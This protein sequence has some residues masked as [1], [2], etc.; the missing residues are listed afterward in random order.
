MAFGETLT[1]SDIIRR[2]LSSWLDNPPDFHDVEQAYKKLG[3]QRRII[4]LLKRQ[5]ESLEDEIKVQSDR[6]RSNDTKQAIIT[7]TNQQRDQLAEL[8]SDLEEM[9]ARIKFLEYAKSM[10]ASASYQSR[11]LYE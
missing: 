9:E 10:Y 2:K 4:R 1:A 11:Q 8:E 3:I 6:P 5:I 7:A